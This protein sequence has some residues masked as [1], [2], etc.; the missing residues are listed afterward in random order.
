M[1]Q[2]RTCIGCRSRASRTALLRVV[3]AD[4]RLSLDATASAPGRGAWVHPTVSCIAT[5]LERRAFRRALRVGDVDE[6]EVRAYADK[7]SEAP[8]SDVTAKVDRTMD[9]S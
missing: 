8:V 1:S 9:Q 2:V 7:L 4:N 3:V 5:A 6:S